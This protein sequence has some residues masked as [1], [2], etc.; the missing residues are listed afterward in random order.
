MHLGKDHT[1]THTQTHNCGNRL[2]TG[3]LYTQIQGL[4]GDRFGI[5]HYADQ[6]LPSRIAFQHMLTIALFSTT[7]KAKERRRKQTNK[8]KQA[9][10][11]S[12]WTAHRGLINLFSFYI[13]ICRFVTCSTR[14]ELP[15]GAILFFSLRIWIAYTNLCLITGFLPINIFI[16]FV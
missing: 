4:N 7:T 14:F 16:G 1:H 11:S 12:R 6:R 15:I 5:W 13:F 9:S 2:R 3:E 8:T 10:R